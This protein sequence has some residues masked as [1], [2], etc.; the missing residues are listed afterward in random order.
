MG[1]LASGLGLLLPAALV[2]WL[3]VDPGSN[4]ELLLPNEHFYVVTLVS[5]LAACTALLVAR[6]AVRLDQFQVL[7][8]ALGFA[9]MAGF[10]AVHGLATPGMIVR[11]ALNTV[12]GGLAPATSDPYAGAYGTGGG[13][14]ASGAAPSPRPGV[15]GAGGRASELSY[16]GTIVG[17]SAFLSLFVAS[18]L[19]AAS[20]PVTA[21]A[22]K[23]RTR[24]SGRT[25]LAAVAVTVVLYAV[26]SV[27]QSDWIASWPLSRPPY[28]YLLAG[29]SVVLLGAAALQ[30][31][32]LYRRS[33]LPTQGALAVA[34]ALLAQAQVAMVVAR[35]W[36]LAW[37]SYHLVM[38]AAL[39]VALAALVLELDRR[40][41]LERF[42]PTELVERVVAGDRLRL[43]GERRLVTILFADLRDSTAMA[44]ALDAEAVVE[45][46]NAYVG[47][48]A[49]CVFAQHGMLDKFMGDGLMAIFGLLEHGDDGA[50]AAARAAR[51]M[52]GAI[53]AVNRARGVD[54]P[55]R[56][57]VGIHTGP[58]V[59]GAIGVPQRLDFTAVGDTVN[60]AARLQE[61]TKEHRSEVIVSRQTAERLP[62]A[63]FRLIA[64]GSAPI[65]GRTEAVELYALA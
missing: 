34:F 6:A 27:W 56:F 26:F 37:W 58:A 10:F 42:L 24:A 61:L 12:G 13:Y 54:R 52:L 38:L 41:G 19:F 63:E 51:Q 3:L 65:R 16:D 49:D 32:R 20:H 29:I 9:G 33:R 25:L 36:T 43:V 15:L 59:V 11:T 28:S 39:I 21:L 60:T 47:A 4:R 53:A 40:R 31:L 18:F 7:L 35:F 57:G 17:L 1:R 64:L 44:E 45:L 5:A 22:I 8:V 30:Y 50:A 14:D 55:V 23:R 46:L 48:L 62:S 2:A